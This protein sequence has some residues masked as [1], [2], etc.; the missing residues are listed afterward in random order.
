LKKGG[1][2]DACKNTGQSSGNFGSRRRE[3]IYNER[4]PRV[5][6]GHKAIEDCP[7]ESYAHKNCD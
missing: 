6:S 5:P 7:F 2:I 1:A 4:I 3:H